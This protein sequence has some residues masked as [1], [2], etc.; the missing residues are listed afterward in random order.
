MKPDGTND[1]QTSSYEEEDTLDLKDRTMED[2]EDLD[3]T[4]AVINEGKD[5][6]Q[7]DEDFKKVITCR[8]I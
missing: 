6:N 2:A 7:D 8:L 4:E 5:N 3:K 1:S